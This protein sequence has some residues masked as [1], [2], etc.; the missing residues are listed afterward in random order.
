[1]HFRPYLFLVVVV[2]CDLEKEIELVKKQIYIDCST[3]KK[4]PIYDPD[5]LREFC[6]SAGARK[7]FDTILNAVSS[8]R[9]SD[10]RV[11]VNKKGWFQ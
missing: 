2:G 9:H 7:L 1:M 6:I 5:R 11:A 10:E 4:K 8:S 3:K